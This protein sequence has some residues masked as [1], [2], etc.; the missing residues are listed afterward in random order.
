MSAANIVTVNETTNVIE[1]KSPGTVG[2]QGGTGAT[3]PQGATGPAGATGA[4]GA[5]GAAGAAATIAVGTTTT[6]SAG[7]NASVTNTGSSS[8]AT[9]N[10]TIPRG[11]TGATG[12]TGAT[13]PTGAQGAAGQAATIAVGTVTTLSAGSSATVTNSGNSSSATFDFGIPRGDYGGDV[14]LDTTPQ[15]GGHLDVNGKDIV[16]TSN[17]DIDLDPNGS[18]KVVFKGNS[19]KGSGQFVLNCEVNSHGITIKGP[20]HS[21]GASYTLTL[22]NTDGNNNEFLKTDG[23][24]NL[25][26][27]GDY[28]TSGTAVAMAIALG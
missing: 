10:F 12:S 19:T 9:F 18:G 8:A 24:G 14:V 3:G 7:S 27:S 15:L 23:S 28:D 13:G 5:T 16:S 4:T 2:P 22:P 6:G 21:A 20:P 1:I 17:G 25:S 26:W 11:D